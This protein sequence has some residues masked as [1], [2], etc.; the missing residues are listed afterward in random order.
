MQRLQQAPQGFNIKL[1]LEIAEE[2][3]VSYCEAEALVLKNG[4]VIAKGVSGH[5]HRE[6]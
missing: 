5:E 3:K 2:I 6:S 1:I 4:K